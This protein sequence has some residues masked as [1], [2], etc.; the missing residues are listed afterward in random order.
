MT[1]DTANTTGDAGDAG[2]TPDW[3]PLARTI[4]GEVVVAGSAA[5]ERLPRPFNA[6][7]HEPR[8]AAVVRCAGP[9]DVAETLRFLAAHG[10]DRAVR[11]GGH[12]FAGHSSTGGVVLDVSPMNGVSV[13]GAAGGVAT[14][15][16]GARLGA[17]Y[18]ALDPHDLAIPGGTCPP[19]GI[20]GLTLGGGLG[21]LGRT[22]GVL[23]DRLVR[24]QVVL[25]DGRIVMCDEHHD[26]DLFW[27]LRG[28]GA[29]NFGVV[30]S[31]EL[32]TVPAPEVTNVHLS[33]P[34]AD[35]TTVIAAWQD[36][37]PHGPDGLAASLKV[38]CSGEV[39]EAPSVDVYAAVAGSDGDATEVVDEL[40]A[41]VRQDPA[42]A[43]RRRM[44]FPETRRFWAQLGAID[45]LGA[46][47]P[48]PDDATPPRHLVARSEFF[49]RPLPPDT[50]AALVD[51][52]AEGR[53]SG[54]ERELDF[55]PWGGAYNRV[56]P[57]ATAFVHREELFQIKHAAVVDPVASAD[58][59]H[60]A[61][62]WVS[63]SWSAVH[64]WGSGRVFQNFADRELGNWADAYYG[65]NLPRLVGVKA[66]YD[67]DNVFRF[68]QSLPTR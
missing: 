20:A 40:V 3:R 46:E 1:D 60:A 67:P 39:V 23:S 53:A 9:A 36:W 37:A 25:A 24:A 18:D 51:N 15:G 41:R 14:V 52:L 22:H 7:Y 66:R 13:E 34:L 32:R 38:T 30:T 31:L 29:G 2:P 62:A 47:I 48:P 11:S 16:A 50:I 8:P 42:T 44:S 65:T 61:H 19:V 10:I 63:R 33:W 12:C 45:D 55:M 57:D 49:R 26:G 27:A 58:A 54:E 28:A 5:Y 64:P 21:I 6:R 59:K 35:A 56:P 4:D 68:D 17:V 43:A